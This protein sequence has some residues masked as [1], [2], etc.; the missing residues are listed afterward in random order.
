MSKEHKKI[1]KWLSL[2]LRHKPE[3]VGI[4][5]DNEGW[6]ELDTLIRA[7]RKQNLGVTHELIEKVVETNDKQRF[8]ISDDGKRIRASQGHSIDVD[9][10]YT[11]REPPPCLYHG[12]ACKNLH[13]IW[14][15]GIQARK[16]QHVHLSSDIPTATAVGMRHGKPC[17]LMID[18]W[19]M[20]K[21]GRAFYLADNNVWLTECVPAGYI[22]EIL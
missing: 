16:R 12:T 9:L 19:Q 11:K 4:A 6:A 15:H 10:G 22:T 7:M 13:S 5:L 18:T 21:D 2:I 3:A 14:A 17:I 20:H 8:R 1:S